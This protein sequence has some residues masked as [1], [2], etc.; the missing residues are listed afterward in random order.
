M[1]S[2][3]RGNC[4]KGESGGIRFA[5]SLKGVELVQVLDYY[6]TT[7]CYGDIGNQNRFIFRGTPSVL[8]IIAEQYWRL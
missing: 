7:Y 4:S 5:M 1:V 3:G 2:Q 8:N 6:S